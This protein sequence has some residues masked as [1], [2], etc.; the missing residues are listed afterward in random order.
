MRQLKDLREAFES[1]QIFRIVALVPHISSLQHLLQ[2]DVMITAGANQ[3]ST[4]V[5]QI[6]SFGI[7][8]HQSNDLYLGWGDVPQTND[9]GRTCCK[10]VGDFFCWQPQSFPS[11]IFNAREKPL[12]YVKMFFCSLGGIKC[13]HRPHRCKRLCSSIQTVLLQSLDGESWN[14][15]CELKIMPSHSISALLH[16]VIASVT[17]RIPARLSK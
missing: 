3:V 1:S 7:S 12:P 6:P 11:K 14:L 2:H 9:D 8:Q 17:D 15:S 10:A 13:Y 16:Q 4:S 5:S